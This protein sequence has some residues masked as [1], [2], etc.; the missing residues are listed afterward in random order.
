MHTLHTAYATLPNPFIA[1]LQLSL[2]L[3][4]IILNASEG[5]ALLGADI[6]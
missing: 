1:I 3:V 2:S 5:N 6:G 4:R